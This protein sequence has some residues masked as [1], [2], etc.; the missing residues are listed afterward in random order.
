MEA[1]VDEPVEVVARVCAIDIGKATVVACVRTPHE[2]LAG[3]RVQQVRELGRQHAVAG[4]V[5]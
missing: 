4:G 5:G 3:R 2:T 1:I